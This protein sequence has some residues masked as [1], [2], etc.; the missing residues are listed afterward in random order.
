M[1]HP[2]RKRFGQHFL[3]DAHVIQ[4]I[5]E[6]IDLKHND[7]VI[8]IGPG[9][10]ALTLP[11]LERYPYQQ[12]L[13]LEIDRDAIKS[14]SNATQKHTD[15][16]IQEADALRTDFA[17]LLPEAENIRL[18]GNLP[19]NIS[20]PLIFHLINFKHRIIDMHFM[21][22]KEVVDRMVAMPGSKTYGRLSVMVQAHWNAEKLF[23]VGPGAFKPPPKVDSAIICLTPKSISHANEYHIKDPAIFADVVRQA[24]SQR[25]KTIRNSLKS[26]LSPENFDQLGLDPQL[27]AERL[28]VLDFISIS[29]YLSSKN[30]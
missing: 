30:Q 7:H 26:F 2:V 9:L 10:G 21:L 8:E 4:R 1:S 17:A 15:F 23:E 16:F 12:Y 6:A 24:F 13:A 11:L 14:L 27:R 28:S 20:T 22:Q 29:N 5:A 3:H 25:R 19:Y 18:I